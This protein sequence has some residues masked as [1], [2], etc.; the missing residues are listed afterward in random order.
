LIRSICD[1]S[2]PLRDQSL[3]LL[4]VCDVE[5]LDG[6]LDGGL[7]VRRFD[8]AMM[9]R[10]LIFS[11]ET[12]ED[13]QTS[14]VK[15]K[16]DYLTNVKAFLDKGVIPVGMMVN[17]KQFVRRT[18]IVEREDDASRLGGLAKARKEA[19]AL[20]STERLGAM[21]LTHRR[22]TKEERKEIKRHF[23]KAREK[24]SAEKLGKIVETFRKQMSKQFTQ[25]ELAY[26]VTRREL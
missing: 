7:F 24:V 20:I 26:T 14:F 19:D 23:E 17:R 2:A 22:W 3:L 6:L 12:Y 8:I 21:V 18:F 10:V 13:L 9:Y 1:L 4:C 11:P 15:A 25:Q 16:N 5:F